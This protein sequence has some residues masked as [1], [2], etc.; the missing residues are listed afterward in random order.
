[1]K[2]YILIGIIMMAIFIPVA[3]LAIKDNNLYLPPAQ[4]EEPT[5]TYRESNSSAISTYSV[6]DEEM[7]MKVEQEIVENEKKH[8]EVRKILIKYNPETYENLYQANKKHY[9]GL[10]LYTTELTSETKEMLKIELDTYE[11]KNLNEEE[12]QLL[13]DDILKNYDDISSIPE[14]KNKA[15]KILNK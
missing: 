10:Q 6:A 14:L 3:V 9:E 4:Q 7:E 5:L 15:D 2:K 13:K 8:E 11:N 12:K 1:M